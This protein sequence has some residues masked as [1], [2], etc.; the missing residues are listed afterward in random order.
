MGLDCASV[1][2]LVSFEDVA[3]DFTWEEWRDLNDA[4]RTLY[5]DV[6]L[7]TYSSL[8]SL[9]YW[10]SKP[11]VSLK[12]EKG[13]EP[14]IIKE[15]PDQSLPDVQIVNDLIE[16]SQESHGRYLWQGVIINGNQST[17]ENAYSMHILNLVRNNENY[18]GVGHEESNEYQNSLLPETDAMCAGKK[19]DEHNISE[20]S[21]SY[22]EHLSQD[23]KIP[24]GQLFEYS[25]KGQS[26]NS[27]PI[28]FVYKIIYMGETT[29]KYSEYWKACNK[30]SVFAP[31]ITQ[32][33]KKTFQGDVCA[34][35]YKKAKLTQHQ[36]IYTREKH[37]KY[38][39]CQ[40]SFIKQSYLISYQGTSAGKAF[41]QKSTLNMHQRSHKS[42]TTYECKESSKDFNQ[43]SVFSMHQRA[44]PGDKP[45]KCNG[46]RK[47]FNKKSSFRM[48]QSTHT[49][50]T[51]YDC[52]ECGKAFKQKSKLSRHQ[53]IHTCE[54]PSECKECGKAFK[55]KSHLRKHQR[56]HTGEK[57]YE[58]KECGKAFKRKSHLSMHQRIHTGEK[59]YECKECG[60]AFKL[61]SHLSKHKRTHTGEKPY[62][63]KECGKAF[64]QKS[65]L[66]MHQS[67]HTDEKPYECKECG[68][69]F[70]QKSNLSMHQRIH[71]DEKPYECKECGKAFNRKSNLSRHQRIHRGE[72]RY[73]CKECGKAFNQKSHLSRH[74]RIHRGEKPYECK[75]CGKAFNQKSNL[76]MHQRIHTGEKPCE[77]NECGKSFFYKVTV[78]KTSGY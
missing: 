17:K 62:E 3:V 44:L 51:H 24:A 36:I 16:R 15:H 39:E 22:H 63:C 14:W 72:K 35:M 40:K 7:E 56:I 66:S 32:V 5:M 18:S 53:R 30:S 50:K 26:C 45:Y 2:E 46:C 34:K 41:N 52:K 19:P 71:T 57:P 54:K 25:D 43:M 9:G 49:G 69:A 55:L 74:Q 29:C 37:D 12:L 33:G 1:K 6:M 4:Q 8:V 42:K 38:S 31:E 64:N 27:V 65:N 10:I 20:K 70:N 76:S 67:I 47:I 58:C 11:E 60:K 23:P 68:K 48:H 59:P 61:K 13:A 77:C 75:E 78:E 73:E 21:Q 28:I